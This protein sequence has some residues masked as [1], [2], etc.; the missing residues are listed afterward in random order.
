MKGNI[1]VSIIIPTYNRAGFL[2]ETLDSILC[3][4]YANL[5][6]IVIDDGSTDNTLSLLKEY[7][8]KDARIKY[9]NRPDTM[10]KGAN[11]CRNYG[12]T[13]SNGDCVNWFDDDDIMLSNFISDKVALFNTDT[14]LVITTGSFTDENLLNHKQINLYETDNIYQE[15]FFWKL[16]ILTPSIFF[17][18]AYLNTV[19]LFDERLATSHEFEFFTR[20]FCDLKKEDYIIKN[21]NS[22]LYRGHKKSTTHKNQTYRFDYKEAESFVLSENLERAIYLNNKIVA[23]SAFRL[24]MNLY[25]KALEN[26]HN[27]NIGYIINVIKEVNIKNKILIV[28]LLTLLKITYGFVNISFTKWNKMINKIPVK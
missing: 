8:K 17:S 11:S 25:K 23:Q 18:R 15:Y 14:K 21:I 20:I 6:C 4:Q 2:S 22:F 10:L 16:K 12:F 9:Y 7:S 24:L 1:L 5:E 27:K 26:K 28:S 19:K 3:Q 13:K